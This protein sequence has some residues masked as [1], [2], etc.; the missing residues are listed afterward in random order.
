MVVVLIS[1]PGMLSI[2]ESLFLVQQTYGHPG[3]Q[4]LEG[5]YE[6]VWIPILVSDSWTDA[7]K[8]SFR[9]LSHSLPW[10]SVKHPWSLNSAAVKFIEQ[11]W[12]YKDSRLMVVLD[13]KGKVTNKN[14]MDMIFVWGP[15]A[16]PFSDSR[17]RELW[18]EQWNLQLLVDEIYPLLTKWV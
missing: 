10:C 4:T 1:K 3:N 18:Q 9:L 12:E 5:S 2:E 7:E 6:I 11:E 8:R 14:A 17:E 15:K 16:Y 13:S